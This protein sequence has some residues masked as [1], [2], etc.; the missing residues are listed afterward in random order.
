[1]KTI[2][3]KHFSGGSDLFSQSIFELLL[4]AHLQLIPGLNEV[5]ELELAFYESKILSDEDIVRRGAYFAQVGECPTYHTLI[6]SG[7]ALQLPRYSSA[8]LRSFFETKQFKTGYATHG[9]TFPIGAN[10]TPR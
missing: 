3:E 8:R 5:Y 4:P 9:D 6:C 10:F 2:P 7:E 1:M